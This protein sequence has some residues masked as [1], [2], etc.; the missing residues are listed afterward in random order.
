MLTLVTLVLG[1]TLSN[2]AP[3]LNEEELNCLTKVVYHEARG[4]P[5]LGQIAVASVVI[6]R[7]NHN[8]YPDNI[9]EIVYQPRQFTDITKTIPNKNTRT[10]SEIKELSEHIM[11]GLVKDPTNGAIFFHNPNKSNKPRI[12]KNLKARIANHDFYS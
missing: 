5:A 3:T 8:Y 2:P 7:L 11:L 4:E 10:W 1:L 6:N 9:C 12:F